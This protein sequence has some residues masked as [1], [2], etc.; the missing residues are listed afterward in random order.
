MAK[1]LKFPAQRTLSQILAEL[2]LAEG[3]LDRLDLSTM[4]RALT[5]AEDARWTA[6]E[7][8]IWLRRDEAKALIEA[9]T[10][11]SWD[12]IQAANL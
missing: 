6:L 5:D 9:Q 2:M 11:V 7:D 10:G 1:I 12:Q 3:E 4:N 8:Q